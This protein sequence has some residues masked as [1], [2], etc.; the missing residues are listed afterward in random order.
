MILAG[1]GHRPAKLGGYGEHIKKRLIQV[2]ESNVRKL[3]PDLI[4]SGMAQGWDMALAHAAIACK[5]PF[6]AYVPFKDQEYLWPV[7]SQLEYKDL[8]TKAKNVVEVCEPGYAPWKM[9][10]RNEA[11]VNA[12]DEVL[13]LWDGSS[14]GTGN[15]IRYAKSKGKLIHNA[16][17]VWI[18]QYELLDLP[19]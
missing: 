4:I 19:F 10:K 3:K 1:T 12:C 13:A 6:L 5:I 2:A 9:Q 17:S 18:N 11:M 15:C 14:G 8:L 16:W 7:R